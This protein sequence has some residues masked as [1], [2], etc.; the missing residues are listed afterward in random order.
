MRPDKKK[1]ID[2]VW[3]DER[4]DS[5]LNKSSMGDEPAQ[6][7]VLLNAYRSMRLADFERFLPRFVAG[8]GDL[9]AR[10][11]SGERLLDEVRRHRQGAGFAQA[12]LAQ[13]AQDA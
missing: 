11:K 6:Y 7:S 13:G 3:D 2:E 9:N 5:F 12:L 4:I 1:V 10:S 8:G